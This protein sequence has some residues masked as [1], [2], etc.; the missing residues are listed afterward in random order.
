M[1]EPYI[2]EIRAFSFSWTPLG[3]IAC[4]GQQVSIY[5]AQALY[6]V[7]ANR[8]GGDQKT[9]FNVPDLRGRA[10]LGA[11]NGP[12]LTPRLLASTGGTETVTLTAAQMAPHQHAVSAILTGVAA[13]LVNAPSNTVVPSRT[14][15]QSN[16]STTDV[17]PWT[18]TLGLDPSTIG[19]ST[20]SAPATQ[21][22]Q[23]MQPWMVTNW[24]IASDGIFPVHSN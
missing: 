12:G 4:N 23:N 13:N 20:G 21:A 10:A 7:I 2:G 22:H 8:Y 16:Y 3:W 9:Y 5:Q 6:A 14:F 11:G 15:N 24:C 1:S 18:S 17:N 19:P